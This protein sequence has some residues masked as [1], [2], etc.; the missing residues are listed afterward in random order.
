M[1]CARSAEWESRVCSRTEASCNAVSLATIASFKQRTGSL[2]EVQS[3]KQVKQDIK[4]CA[5]AWWES[6]PGL[7]FKAS[8]VPQ[9]PEF[10]LFTLEQYSIMTFQTL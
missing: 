2:I 3:N 8:K 6:V 4:Y 9:T 1:R 5:E 10:K 7:Y